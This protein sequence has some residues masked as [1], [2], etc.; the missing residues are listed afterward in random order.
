[1]RVTMPD[2][3][4]RQKRKVSTRRVH[5]SERDVAIICRV[6]LDAR[7]PLK[8]DEIVSHVSDELGHTWTRQALERHSA[9]KEAYRTR[10]ADKSSNVV[11]PAVTVL[12]N[13]IAVLQQENERLEKLVKTFQE[14]FVR[15]QYNA[16]SENISP[17]VLDKPLPTVV[18][19]WSD[20]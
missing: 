17:D 4:R 6:I 3:R 19:R 2:R 12:M 10:R 8:W 7:R 16:H 20:K 5:I 9:I 15:Y 13:K 11:D 1:M 18:R 14:M